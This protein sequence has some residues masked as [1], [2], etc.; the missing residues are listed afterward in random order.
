[1]RHQLEMLR[2]QVARPASSRRTGPWPPC[3][4][5]LLVTPSILLRWHRDAMR[6]RW[7]YPHRR[8]GRPALGPG[9]IELIL[10]LAREN[11]RWGYLRIQGWSNLM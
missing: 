2:R 11:R 5:G 3:W 7:T 8:P 10:R 6:R 4:P 1:M 9:V